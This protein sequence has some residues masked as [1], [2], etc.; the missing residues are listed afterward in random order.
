MWLTHT[1]ES[2]VAIF[3]V[4]YPEEVDVD[5]FY[6][7]LSHTLVRAL[8]VAFNLDERE[9]NVFLAPGIEEE[10]PQ[11]VVIYETTTGGTG[12][13]DSLKEQGRLSMMVSRARELLH[14]CDPDGGCEKACYECLLSFYNQRE[15]HLFD[16]K[17]VLSWLQS[18]GK[19]ALVVERE[20]SS[21]DL[22][23]L[24]AACQ[25]ELEKKVLRAIAEREYRLPDEA[26]K[27]IYKDEE[28]IAQADFFYEPR[29]VIF[30]DGSPHEKESV[31]DGDERKRKEL[32]RLGYRYL[33]ITP[34]DFDEKL[35]ILGRMLG[36]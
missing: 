26:Q 20:T 36:A 10:I 28:P 16:R 14:E 2:D 32:R 23:T 24:L 4:P 3:D 29:Y 25:S 13:L 15:H 8:L 33:V 34:Q 18:I 19:K 21:N 5:V 12:V 9:L 31:K 1:Q 17:V 27:T 7:T 35:D 30:V 6:H 22:E 11:R